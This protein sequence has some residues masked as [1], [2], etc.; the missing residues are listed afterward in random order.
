MLPL[1]G[2]SEDALRESAERY[3]SWLDEFAGELSSGAAA[4]EPLLSDMAWTAAVGRSHFAHR[5]GVVF[6]DAASLREGLGALAESDEF[7]KPQVAARVAFAFAG[8]GGCRVGM[9]EE[10]YESEPVARAV[11]DRCDEVIRVERGASLLDVMFGRSGELDDPAWSQPAAFA[12]GC[13][14]TAL[15]ASVGVRPNVVF[16]AGSGEIAA[17]HAAGVFTLEEGLRFAAR[18]GALME[19]VSGGEGVEAALD[20]VETALEGVVTALPSLMLVNQVTGR[21]LGSG[22]TMDG[23]Y[24]RRQASETAALDECARTLA[25]SGVEVVVEVGADAALGPGVLS[26]WP[27][28]AGEDGTSTNGAA[29]PVVLSSLNR[30]SGSGAGFVEAVAR[31]YEAG[32]ALDFAGLFA[33][34]ERRRISLPGYPFQRR[35]FWFEAL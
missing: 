10:L 25:E 18:R 19:A 35:R 16:G 22:E 14:L 5:A 13:A 33:G 4:A 30:A 3:L 31:A 24:W 32:L 6:E 7:Q 28:S 15:W 26:A 34:E 21:A 11:L 27:E 23:A 17:A 9:G 2:K 20:D 8:E 1:S 29:P 12:L